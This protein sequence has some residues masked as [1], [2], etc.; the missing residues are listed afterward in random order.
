M[1]YTFCMQDFFFSLWNHMPWVWLVL[2]VVFILIEATTMSLTT[3]WFAC[4]AFVMV[5]ISLLPLFRPHFI[6]HLYY[7]IL[8]RCPLTRFC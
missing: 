3:I 4:A 5:F 6:L 2:T 1:H 8:R 7:H